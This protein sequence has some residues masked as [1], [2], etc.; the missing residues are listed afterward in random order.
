M[1]LGSFLN[2]FKGFV[3][4][5]VSLIE[6]NL[7]KLDLTWNLVFQIFSIFKTTAIGCIIP[8]SHMNWGYFITFESILSIFY[9]VDILVTVK[10]DDFNLYRCES[11]I[12]VM[13]MI[14]SL[15]YEIGIM[16]LLMCYCCLTMVT[17]AKRQLYFG[18]KMTINGYYRYDYGICNVLLCKNSIANYASD[19]YNFN[20][21]IILCIKHGFTKIKKIKLSN[22][23]MYIT[24]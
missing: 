1:A 12:I 24:C 9:D 14:L 10:Y 15:M 7:T 4:E 5:M 6:S 2:C 11:S 8:I 13:I 22:Y 23:T 20:D 16:M 17:I 18:M 19:K 3:N 21:C